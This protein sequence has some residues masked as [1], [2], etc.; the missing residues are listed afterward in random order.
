MMTGD[1][2]ESVNFA[3]YDIAGGRF[4]RIRSAR[5]GRRATVS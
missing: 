3:M 1:R 4:V 2:R 5:F